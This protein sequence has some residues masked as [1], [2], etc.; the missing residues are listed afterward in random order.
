MNNIKNKSVRA[1]YEEL[2]IEGYYKL[3]NKDYTNP[4]IKEIEYLLK[5]EIK[6]NYFGT[7]I[8]DLCCGSGEVT[9][10]LRKYEDTQKYN[11]EGLDPYTV[12]AYE[13]N[14]NNTCLIYDFKDIVQGALENK[15]YDTIICSFAMHLCEESMLNSL[16]Y[17]LNLIANTLVI[18]T[19]HKRPEI[20][21][22]WKETYRQKLNKVT[23]RTYKKETWYD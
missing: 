7:N 2:G 4:H 14:T 3:H 17:Q 12:R 8:L 16:L 6:K 5:Q 18:I 23:L 15:R 19:P 21:Y 11:I 10:I 20:N 13:K 9:N 1:G 22:W